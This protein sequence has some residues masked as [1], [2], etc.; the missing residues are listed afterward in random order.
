MTNPVRVVQTDT[1][2][3]YLGDAADWPGRYLIP[4]HVDLILTNPYGP[5]PIALNGFPLIAH[6]W[7]HR[8]AEAEIWC[9]TALTHE[10]GRWNQGREAFWSANL[11]DDL[12][13][14]TVDLSAYAP[15]PGGWYPEQLVRDLLT[16]FAKPGMTIFD[17]FM[18]RGTVGKIAVEMGMRYIGVEQLES[19]LA[20]A[21]LYLNV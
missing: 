9:H 17:G 16:V 2:T 19:H 15:E 20:L 4:E 5:L 6:Q 1:M 3:L 8:K 14:K 13:A 10:V 21:R 18:G 7:R 11:P 12:A